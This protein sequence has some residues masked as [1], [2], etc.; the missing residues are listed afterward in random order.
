MTIGKLLVLDLI[1]VFC[2]GLITLILR[3]CWFWYKRTTYARN[4]M[5]SDIAVIIAS[6]A[7]PVVIGTVIPVLES[8]CLT[9]VQQNIFGVFRIIPALFIVASILGLLSTRQINERKILASVLLIGILALGVINA[10]VTLDPCIEPKSIQEIDLSFVSYSWLG[11]VL[12]AALT[13]AA[14]IITIFEWIRKRWPSVKE[15]HRKKNTK[16]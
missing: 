6:S 9:K 1:L 13:L 2:L 10:I 11:S 4:T 3:R 16:I 14:A 8:I 12:F 15:G 5:F 7:L